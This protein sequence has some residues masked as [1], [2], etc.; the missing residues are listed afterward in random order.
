MQVACVRETESDLQVRGSVSCCVP[1]FLQLLIP[2]SLD[3]WIYFS[4]QKAGE[5][6]KR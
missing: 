2:I 6:E 5:E 4:P 3:K 1:S